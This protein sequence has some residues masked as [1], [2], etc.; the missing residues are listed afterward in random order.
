MR[1]APPLAGIWRALADWVRPPPIRRW[2]DLTRFLSGEASYLTQ[3]STYEFCRNTLAWYGQHHFG[4]DDFNEV[5]R[6]CRWETFAAVLADM[7][8]LT[9][10]RLGGAVADS[11]ELRRRLARC[12]SAGLAEY[13]VPTHRP[14][15]WSDMVEEV[16]R[17]LAE[18]RIAGTTPSIAELGRATARK[19]HAIVPV[20]S[21]NKVE[22]QRVIENAITFG[23]TAFSD[24]ARRRIR[25]DELAADR[26]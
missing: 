17:R 23:L 6:V 9:Q 13:P 4:R 24:R 14:V 18:T 25:P 16:E 7:T 22:D 21:E 19:V 2:T 15:G 5:F 8:Q 1:K 10:G 12:Y 11:V 3:R 20:R 26:D